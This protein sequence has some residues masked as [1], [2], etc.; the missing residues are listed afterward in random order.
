MIDC[1]D[2]Q[3]FLQPYLDGEIDGEER[4]FISA[5]LQSCETCQQIA[6]FEQAF[7]DTVRRHADAPVDAPPRLRER[8]LRALDA[9]E[10][11]E[12]RFVRWARVVI[13]AA[14]AVLLVVGV[15]IS[16]RGGVSSAVATLADQSIDW[17]RR[18]VPMDVTG[19]SPTIRRFFLD[20]VPFA[21]R[22]PV[23]KQA[24]THL[25]G[26]RLSTLRSHQAAYLVYQVG[27][28]RVSVFIFDASTMAPEGR[29][30]RVGARDVRWSQRRGYNVAMYR[31]GGTGYVVASDLARGKLVQFI[32]SSR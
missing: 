24:R 8:V 32:S 4:I 28:R 20:K 19:S 18:D 7:R 3:R 23:F 25:V 13:P 26:G 17:H 27:G 31:S 9:E 15:A 22:P 2:V 21:V 10:R 14:A 6:R 16:E 30:R 1:D 29:S 12:S 5:H 11:P